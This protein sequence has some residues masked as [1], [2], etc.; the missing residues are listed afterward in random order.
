MRKA[1]LENLAPL[2]KPGSDLAIEEAVM[3]RL[4]DSNVTL[5]RGEYDEAALC[6]KDVKIAA[7]ACLCRLSI[8]GQQ[9]VRSA[10]EVL[11]LIDDLPVSVKSMVVAAIEHFP[12]VVH[13]EYVNVLPVPGCPEEA[14]FQ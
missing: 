7:I 6:D 11:Q 12:E 5:N 1:V 10:L 14:L 4:E 2:Y 3:P 9:W 8:H 13:A